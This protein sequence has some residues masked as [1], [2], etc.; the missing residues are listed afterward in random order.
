METKQLV[1]QAVENLQRQIAQSIKEDLPERSPYVDG[2]YYFGDAKLVVSTTGERASIEI[3]C[4]NDELLKECNHL[5]ISELYDRRDTLK[6]ELAK[7][8][9]EL[10]EGAK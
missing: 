7:I 4:H 5:H 8:D 10:G 9:K 1:R 6:K 3:E 2:I